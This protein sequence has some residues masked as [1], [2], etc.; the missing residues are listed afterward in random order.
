MWRQWARSVTFFQLTKKE[1]DVIVTATADDDEIVEH[2]RDQQ[3][4]TVKGEGKKGANKYTLDIAFLCKDLHCINPFINFNTWYHVDEEHWNGDTIKPMGK[5]TPTY[6]TTSTSHLLLLYKVFFKIIQLNVSTEKWRQ[7]IKWNEC[8]L[9]VCLLDVWYQKYYIFCMSCH[10]T[11]LVTSK[12]TFWLN[13]IVIFVILPCP[14]HKCQLISITEPLK[15]YKVLRM[16]GFT[17]STAP[18]LAATGFISS[19][20][21]HCWI[22]C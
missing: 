9:C 14:S 12:L 10:Q 18:A 11:W 20:T 16:S 5:H 6:H 8:E 1:G 21:W 17:I 7:Q 4:K 3:L 15:T 2:T 19:K 13:C 22:D